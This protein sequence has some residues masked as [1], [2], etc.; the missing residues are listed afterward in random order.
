MVIRSLRFFLFGLVLVVGV[1]MSSGVVLAYNCWDYDADQTTCNSKS[2]CTYHSESWGGWCEELNCW[3]LWAQSDCENTTLTAEIGK[4][5]QWK[6]SSSWGWC[7]QTT[8]W[9]L[10]RTNQSY[11][12][13]SSANGGL[14]C[15]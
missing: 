14:N 15:E 2:D 5:C 1:L 6:S 4:T 9:S 12:G 3:T 11:C 8:C 13:N 10:E 7:S